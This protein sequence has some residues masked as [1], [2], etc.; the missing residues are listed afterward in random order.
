MKNKAIEL[1]I[2]ESEIGAG[3]RGSSLGPSALKL[4]SLNL[5]IDFFKQYPSRI[6]RNQNDA[7][8][9]E[10]TFPYAKY[11]DSI[12]VVYSA[13][14]KEVSSVLLNQ[15]FPLVVSADHASAAATIA[16]I[17]K[18]F[19]DKRLGVVWIDAHADLHSPYTT[20]SGNVHGMPLACALGLDNLDRQINEPDPRGVEHWE[21]M[22]A[23]GGKSPSFKTTDLRFVGVRDTEEPENHFM[24]KYE[25]PNYTVDQLRNAGPKKIA[26]EL[27]D[28]LS[29]CD[30]L[31]VSFDVDSMDPDVVS[32]GTGTP[33][34]NGLLPDEARDLIHELVKDSRL[35]CFEVVEVNPL[36]DNKC[37]KMAEETLKILDSTAKIIAS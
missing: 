16:G 21:A 9:A 26:G 14:C 31:Y 3:T 22:K 35:V 11:I 20:P 32:Y 1:V 34:K 13:H 29:D 6:V 25:I 24:S 33:V 15:R 30:I 5:E 27:L 37:N 36:L 7:L 17:V 18:A 28:S 23:L 12:S 8:F 4:A 2:Q 19:P 10:D